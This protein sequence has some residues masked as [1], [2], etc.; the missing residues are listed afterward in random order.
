M[1]SAVGSQGSS[2]A[3]SCAVST[4]LRHVVVRAGVEAALALAGRHLAGDGDDGQ[5]REPL[6][7]PDGPDGVV[8][9]HDRHHD[10]HE[11]DVDVRRRLEHGQAAGTALRHRDDRAAPLE[12]R[13]HRED[14]AE[15]VV[16]D[17]HPRPVEVISTPEG[18]VRRA[19]IRWAR[20]VGIGTRGD[21]RLVT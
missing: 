17:E 8:P 5:R 4:G 1:R 16:D 12:Q 14:V 3:K 10:V 18:R 21:A 20:A 11:D 15:V 19:W 9:V 2:A 6:D 7:P 13:R